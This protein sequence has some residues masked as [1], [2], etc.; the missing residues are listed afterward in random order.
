[1][2]TILKELI[3]LYLLA[4]LYYIPL[5]YVVWGDV[6]GLLMKISRIKKEP[7]GYETIKLFLKSEEYEQHKRK[8]YKKF[9]Y[10]LI[11]C[12]MA[13]GIF[14]IFGA[15]DAVAVTSA[16]VALVFSYV[17]IAS[18]ESK[19][20]RNV[21]QNFLNR[22]IVYPSVEADFE[23]NYQRRTPAGD[24]YR[25]DHQID[26]NHR[27]I[28]VHHYYDVEKVFPGESALGTITFVDLEYYPNSLFVGQ[29]LTILEGERIVGHARVIKV[30]SPVLEKSIEK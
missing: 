25:A 18:K 20:R 19:E 12:G 5:I 22:V 30:N 10:P 13:W 26:D 29:E 23:F 6:M 21:K 16:H 8:W 1:M 14:R 2:I 28:G 4:L 3:I 27:G 17:I 15:E 9:L 24:G 11:V 7:R